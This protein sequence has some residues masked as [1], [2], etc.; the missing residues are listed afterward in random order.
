MKREITITID[1]PAGA[2]KTTLARYLATD[3][4]IRHGVQVKLIDDGNRPVSVPDV[5]ETLEN[6]FDANVTII[7]EQ[8]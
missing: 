6:Y 1:G 5:H 4:K 2:G 8:K 7:V 3:L